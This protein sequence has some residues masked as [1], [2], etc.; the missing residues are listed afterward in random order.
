MQGLNSV[1]EA[2]P[3]KQRADIPIKTKKDRRAEISLSVPK[4][5]SKKRNP[6]R[7]GLN[8]EG[9][10]GDSRFHGNDSVSKNDRLDSHSHENGNLNDSVSENDSWDKNSIPVGIASQKKL[11]K[12]SVK[13]ASQ[14]KLAKNSVKLA[15][16]K[17]LAKNSVK[18]ASQKKLAKSPSLKLVNL[19][20]AK[21]KPD[22]IKT[23]GYQI[24]YIKKES[25]F[26]KIK[27]QK[28]D[29]IQS[30][31]EQP[32]YSKKQVYQTIS[33]IVKKQK[34]FSMTITRNKKNFLIDYKID[35][36][37]EKKRFL[38]SN[39]Q[40]IKTLI[41]TKKTSEKKSKTIQDKEIKKTKMVQNEKETKTNKAKAIKNKQKE[42]NP[43]DEPETDQDEKPAKVKKQLVPEKYKTHL[44]K[45]YV[46]SP[47]SFVYKK[48]DFDSQKL[49]PLA[50]GKKILISKKIFRPSHNFGSFHKVFLF[51]EKKVV[52]YISEAEVVSEFLSQ[53][54][55]HKSNPAYRLAKK[56]IEQDKVLDL[57]LIEKVRQQNQTKPKTPPATKSKRRYVGLSMG[58]LYNSPFTLTQKDIYIGL[59]LSG[60]DLLISYLNMDLNLTADLDF[61]FFHFDILTALPILKSDP[62]YLFVMGG[63]KLEANTRVND[64]VDYGAAGALSLVIPANQKL[65]LRIDAKAEYGLRTQSY[66]YSFLG[67]LQVPF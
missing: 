43:T 25:L 22:A 58:F 28:D 59:K 20:K 31:E 32:I 4:H 47:N 44:Q 18:L 35:I 53:K 21:Q 5:I 56:Q 41:K 36:S 34:K 52:G 2:I 27:L 24:R 55:K 46:V 66:I 16:Q 15:S 17:K 30:I 6:Y 9:F 10:S 38:I 63:L 33:K 7:S 64:P 11:A 14:K 23:S 40:K 39:V 67:S 8:F 61:K 45:A 1:G 57:D 42:T 54:G 65:L 51:R 48:P 29:I 26:E 50:I 62:Y 37:K 60:Y 13:L 49:Y 19:Q 3:S 12:N